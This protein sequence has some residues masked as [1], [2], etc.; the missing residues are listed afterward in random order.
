[1]FPSTIPN[2]LLNGCAVTGEK[3]LPSVGSLAL[4]FYVGVSLEA[5]KVVSIKY[6]TLVEW[7]E[8]P[9]KNVV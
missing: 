5:R 1:M 9:V 7:F 3:Q 6:F 8:S 4:Q 2:A